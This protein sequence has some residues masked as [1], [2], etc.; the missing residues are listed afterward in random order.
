MYTILG[1]DKKFGAEKRVNI[2]CI[3]LQKFENSK[4]YAYD[5]LREI[6]LMRILNN[7]EN[8]ISA[9]DIFKS[10]NHMYIVS[11]QFAEVDLEAIIR[12]N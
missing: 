4:I 11:E 3:S 7:H 10:E 1:I 6:K 9:C 12:S 5:M 8:L 2:T